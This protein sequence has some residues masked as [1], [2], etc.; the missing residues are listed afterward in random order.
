MHEYRIVELL[1]RKIAGEA[2]TEELGE[3]S[4]LLSQY[5]DAVYYE[6]L[7]E[8]VWNMGHEEEREEVSEAF[9]KHKLNFPEELD[10]ES[11][12]QTEGGFFKRSFLVYTTLALVILS[13]SIYF[14]KFYSSSDKDVRVN[15]YAGKGV[16]K[17]IKLPDGTLVRLNSGSRLSYD[18]DMQNHNQRDVLLTGEAFFKVAHDKRHPFVVKTN[19]VRIKVLGTEFNV[20]EYPG[21]RESETTLINGSIELTVNDRSDQKFLLKPS[22][23]FALVK[24]TRKQAD[25]NQKSVL[26]IE[27]IAPV[28]VGNDEY[29][30]EI[31]WTENKFVFQ[32]ESFEDLIP[33][34]ERWYNVQII[35]VDPKIRSYRYTGVFIDE[36]IIQ[37]LEAMQL[38]KSFHY[39]FKFK[40]NEIKIY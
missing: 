19:K 9:E 3:L 26:M 7:L 36:N 17:E 35:L 1:T 12:A 8:Q 40:E 14:T 25:K 4:Y 29:L 32:N 28:K 31:S 27:N 16:R 24:D 21:D 37:A 11:P 15:I 13:A 38:I 5:P 10:F 2:T 30:E 20:R 6:A 39:K 34:L 23:K 33:K 18:L 22:E